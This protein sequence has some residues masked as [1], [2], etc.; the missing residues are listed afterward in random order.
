MRFGCLPGDATGGASGTIE[1]GGLPASNSI[2]RTIR[3]VMATAT[4]T[5]SFCHFGMGDFEESSCKLILHDD[6]TSAETDGA[7][8][9][10]M[11]IALD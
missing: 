11:R 7:E 9:P 8:P 6:N 1:E 4:T 10:A 3:K 5:H 2:L